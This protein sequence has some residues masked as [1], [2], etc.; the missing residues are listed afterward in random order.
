MG[1]H[2]VPRSP[3][4]TRSLLRCCSP[5]VLQVWFYEGPKLMAQR[6]YLDCVQQVQLNM[7]HAAV[8]T[9]G[10]VSLHPLQVRARP[11]QP[12]GKQA[13]TACR[14]NNPMCRPSLYNLFC[15]CPAKSQCWRLPLCSWREDFNVS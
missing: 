4:C 7:D 2:V 13:H 5:L 3:C 12:S 15:A 14:M 10:R 11:R 1:V 6:S 9:E 8:L